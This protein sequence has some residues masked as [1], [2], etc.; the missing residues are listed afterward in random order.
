MVRDFVLYLSGL[1]LNTFIALIIASEL[2]LTNNIKKILKSTWWEDVDR[3]IWL[4]N[5][6]I[7]IFMLVVSELVS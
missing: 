7:L 1:R 5:V 4:R 6:A 3:T 2:T